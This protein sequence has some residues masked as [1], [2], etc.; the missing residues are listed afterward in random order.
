MDPFS[1][2]PEKERGDLA[3]PLVRCKPGRGV[4]GVILSDDTIGAYTHYWRGRTQICTRPECDA[5]NADRRPRWYGYLGVWNPESRARAIFEVTP[6]CMESIDYYFTKFG[7]L[8]GA[9]IKLCR[10]SPKINARVIAELKAGNYA[11][12]KLPEAI[13]VRGILT[14]MWEIKEETTKATAAHRHDETVLHELEKKRKLNL[15]Q[16]TNGH[17]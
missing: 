4:S 8:R 15:G 16:L 17:S 12:D 11:G 3:I 6:S 13:D 5:C 1:R 2:R 10:A 7:S 14:K 9:E